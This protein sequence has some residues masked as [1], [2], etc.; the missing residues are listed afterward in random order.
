MKSK[1]HIV[2]FSHGF[3]TKK[4]DRGLLSGPHG[5]AEALAE[6]NIETILFDYNNIDE[7]KNIITVKPLSVQVRILES[8]IKKSREENKDAIIDI[9]AH[10]QGCLTPA[11][12]LPEGIRKMIFIAPSLNVDNQR[13]INL[14]KDHPDTMIDMNGISKLG[15]KDGTTTIVPS[16]YWTDREKA[17]PIRFYNK[18]SN[19]TDITIIRAK[20]DDI[21]R[22]LNTNGLMENIKIIDLDG[23]HSFNGKYRK[24]LIETIK[25]IIFNSC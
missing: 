10:S 21:L 4:D 9:I 22:N 11:L 12:L 25:K 15:R 1:K 18:L 19:I 23:D 8:I 14:F 2:I 6:Q 3:G 20:G 7:E 13:M 5:I 24:D 16:L 17:D